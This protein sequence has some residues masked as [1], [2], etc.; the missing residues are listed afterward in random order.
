LAPRAAAQ[1]EYRDPQKQ[2]AVFFFMSAFAAADIPPFL[3]TIFSAPF[4]VGFIPRPL[5][6]PCRYIARVFFQV[7]FICAGVFYY[8]CFVFKK[9][10]QYLIE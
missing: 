4:F 5:L 3:I 6:T 8:H 2:I 1:S 10:Y 7:S 9:L